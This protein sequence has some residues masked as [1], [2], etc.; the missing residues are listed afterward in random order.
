MT[1]KITALII[2]DG[3]GIAPEGP[4]SAISTENT[5]VLT[6]LKEK[7]PNSSLGASGLSVGLPDGQMGNSEVG[8][9]NIGAGRIVHQELTR[10]T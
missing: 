7:Y 4:S 5:P 3:F 8:H 2:M 9:L 6:A 10:I 1:K